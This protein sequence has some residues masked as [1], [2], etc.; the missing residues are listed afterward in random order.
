MMNKQSRI[1]KMIS[2]LAG[3]P[4]LI[5]CAVTGLGVVGQA[6]AAL[7]YYTFTGTA[8]SVVDADGVTGFSVGDAVTY[9]F[10]I[11][12]GLQSSFTKYDG[13]V[14]T[15]SDL[16]TQ[17]RF[18]ADY[19]SGNALPVH[20][21]DP[22]YVGGGFVAEY[23]RAYDTTSN[24][25]GGLTTNSANNLLSFTVLGGTFSSLAV[26]DGNAVGG[27]NIISSNFMY[28]R[29]ATGGLTNARVLSNNLVLAS[30][31][32]QSSLTASV[33]AVPEPEIYAMMGIGLGLIG[34]IGRKKK[35]KAAAAA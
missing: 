20:P 30:I 13:T 28:Y 11:D 9:E 21:T 16:S 25:T 10:A 35:L 14:F 8:T 19:V 26:G 18:Y 6:Q 33:T 29:N 2:K 31:S 4:V 5:L 23:N 27:A 12:F 22:Y 32:P 1:F 17:D 15:E 7:Q 24:G 34:W 3:L